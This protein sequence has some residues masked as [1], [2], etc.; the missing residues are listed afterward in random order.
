MGNFYTNLCTYGASQQT[1][2]AAMAGR[3]A[4]IS[5]QINGVVVVFDEQCE[6]QDPDDLAGLAAHLSTVCKCPVLATMIH[7]DSVLAY[8]LY[9]NGRLADTYNSC[10]GYFGSGDE[11][12]NDDGGDDESPS[13][14]NAVALAAAFLPGANTPEAVAAIE[15]ILRAGSDEYVFEVERHQALAEALK[16]P[17]FVAGAGYNY[18]VDGDV[19]GLPELLRL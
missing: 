10:P 1:V 17:D 12:G 3:D 18:V 6:S 4:M 15:A 5:P 2:R 8:V 16:L 11:E 7:D 14:G 19:D 13:G 9:D